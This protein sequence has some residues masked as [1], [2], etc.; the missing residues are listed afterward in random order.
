MVEISKLMKAGSQET[1]ESGIKVESPG[2]LRIG[3]SESRK[4][5]RSCFPLYRK[6]WMLQ[7]Y[8]KS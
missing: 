2:I 4:G 5:S 8:L 1:E 6:Q 3:K 7:C